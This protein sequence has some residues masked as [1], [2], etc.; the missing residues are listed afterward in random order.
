MG[1]TSPR[2]SGTTPRRPP[3]IAQLRVWDLETWEEPFRRPDDGWVDG[4]A[5]S[6]DSEHLALSLSEPCC[7][8]SEGPRI[9]VVRVLDGAG[10]QVTTFRDEEDMVQ[11]TFLGLHA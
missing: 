3:R 5:W 9:G 11:I 6:P 2:S 1:A 8:Q 4:M 10:R 7:G